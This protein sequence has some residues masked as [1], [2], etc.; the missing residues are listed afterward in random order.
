M[1]VK[2]GSLV[3]LI[4]QYDKTSPRGAQKPTNT[5]ERM[6]TMSRPDYIKVDDIITRS[7]LFTEREKTKYRKEVRQRIREGKA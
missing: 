4:G 7:P 2:S 1:S 5:L 3:F 6:I